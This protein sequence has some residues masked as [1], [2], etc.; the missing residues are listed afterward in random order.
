M[1]SI[2]MLRSPAYRWTIVVNGR[3]I[4]AH[5]A[6]HPTSPVDVDAYGHPIVL[7]LPD[8][9]VIPW[10]AIDYLLPEFGPPRAS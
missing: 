2:E 8:G 1:T 10:E 9:R 3:A 4:A 6:L 7:R 5:T